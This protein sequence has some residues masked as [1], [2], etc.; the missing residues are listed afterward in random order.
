MS[1]KQ[2]RTRSAARE[3]VDGNGNRKLSSGRV[4]QKYGNSI[5]VTLPL[6]GRLLVGSHWPGVVVTI[7]VI[8]GGATMN[9]RVLRRTQ[10]L[11][12]AH[13]AAVEVFI[14][15]CLLL[16][17]AFLLLTATADPGIVFSTPCEQGDE[18]DA[19]LVLSQA[20]YC[21]VCNVYQLP[22]LKIHHCQD[23][24][25]CIEGMDHHCPW[26]VSPVSIALLYRHI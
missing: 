7:F 16:T 9:V 17:T 26:M 3:R 21:D 18:E 8:V 2:I 11:D 19:Q 13:K 22:R 6:V 12:D 15:V 4:C 25:Y 23:C 24:N 1:N 5:I 20:P 10:S 14:S